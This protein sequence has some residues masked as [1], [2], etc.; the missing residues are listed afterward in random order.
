VRGNIGCTLVFPLLL[1]VYKLLFYG[2]GEGGCQQPK[3]QYQSYLFAFFFYLK[4]KREGRFDMFRNKRLKSQIIFA[5]QD[6][7][8]SR[9]ATGRLEMKGIFYDR[10]N[11]WDEENRDEWVAPDPDLGIVVAEEK[12]RQFFPDYALSEHESEPEEVQYYYNEDTKYWAVRIEFQ[13]GAKPSAGK[14]FAV[15]T[16]FA[17]PTH[18]L[19]EF[20]WYWDGTG[21]DEW[22]FDDEAVCLRVVGNYRSGTGLTARSTRVVVYQKAVHVKSYREYVGDEKPKL[23]P[24]VIWAQ[25]INRNYGVDERRHDPNPDYRGDWTGFAVGMIKVQESVPDSWYPGELTNMAF[26]RPI[27]GDDLDKVIEA[28]LTA[29]VSGFQKTSCRHFHEHTVYIGTKEKSRVPLYLCL[30]CRVRGI[31]WTDF[32]GRNCKDLCPYFRRAVKAIID[33]ADPL[34]GWFNWQGNNLLSSRRWMEDGE[35]A[36]YVITYIRKASSQFIRRVVL[37]LNT[38]T[39]EAWLYGYSG[40]IPST[41]KEFDQKYTSGR[42]IA[43]YMGASDVDLSEQE[44]AEAIG[45]GDII[46]ESIENGEAYINV[47]GCMPLYALGH[48]A[49]E[50]VE[51]VG[52]KAPIYSDDEFEYFLL[53]IPHVVDGPNGLDIVVDECVYHY[54]NDGYEFVVRRKKK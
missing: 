18:K 33:K 19:G 42:K 6:P 31:D 21:V 47:R 5:E 24:G 40:T 37:L 52:S 36:V 45:Q 4:I 20:Q 38:R 7:K 13:P 26:Q 44:V 43:G 27:I 28:V 54:H 16:R 48:V 35:F 49:V 17:Y 41:K 29:E 23:E 15:R 9:K 25:F 12:F 53:F 10:E 11:R 2:F 30:S 14:F 39:R 46:W 8:K 1:Q 32:I 22:W 51:E 34:P 3:E 50:K